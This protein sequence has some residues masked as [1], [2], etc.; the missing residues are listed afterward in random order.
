KIQEQLRNFYKQQRLDQKENLRKKREI[1]EKIKE[2]ATSENMEE[3]VADVKS[4]Q[5]EF[6]QIG[7]VAIKQKNRMWY[8]YR[9]ACDVIYNAAKS[10][11]NTEQKTTSGTPK[12]TQSPS[13]SNIKQKQAEMFRLRKE[14]E[15]L[16]EVILQYAD[17]KTYIKP[18][19]KGVDLIDE[20][21]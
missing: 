16:N 19:K 10:K 14:C 17:T 6:Q 3:I 11:A 2:L 18:N 13:R 15:K 20:I 7:F 1:T 9:E 8:E 21:Q 12:S 4:L 5:Q